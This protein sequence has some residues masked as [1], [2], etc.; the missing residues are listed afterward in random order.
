MEHWNGQAAKRGA[1]RMQQILDARVPF[2]E[3][4]TYEKASGQAE[5]LALFRNPAMLTSSVIGGGDEGS[6]GKNGF[7]FLLA[8]AF[9]VLHPKRQLMADYVRYMD[10]LIGDAQKPYAVSK[11]PL[12]SPGDLITEMEAPL[13]AQARLKDVASG[14]TQS[15]LLAVALALRAY[16][17]DQGHFPDNLNE[18]CPNYLSRIPRDSFALS[19]SLLYRRTRAD[20]LLYSIGPD[21]VDDGGR[22]IV[23]RSGRSGEL[24]HNVYLDRTSVLKG[25]IVAGVNV[26]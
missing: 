16:R 11:P 6:S 15:A 2:S 19:G 24:R 14:E 20:Y 5:R 18:L 8:Q 13:Y 4:L 26:F 25:D 12:P 7:A 21:G 23:S 10:H 17:V 1:Q 22:A 3:T 9:Y